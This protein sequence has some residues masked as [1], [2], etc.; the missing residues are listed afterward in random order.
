MFLIIVNIKF[1]TFTCC[2]NCNTLL[3]KIYLQL[4][5]GVCFYGF[6]YFVEKCLT[7]RY[8][9]DTNIERVPFEYVSKETG[10]H[11]T[12]AIII[13]SPGSMFPAAAATEIFST[14]KYLARINGI[15]KYKILLWGIVTI[16]PPVAEKIIAKTFLSVAF[17]KRAGNNLVCIYIFYRHRH[18][19]AFQNCK[20]IVSHEKI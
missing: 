17:K 10:N 5:I 15:I 8:R 6:E 3:W 2:K 12:K 16:I 9:K 13:Y 4:C 7:H 19:C 20:L 11:T 1:F 18:C 14:N